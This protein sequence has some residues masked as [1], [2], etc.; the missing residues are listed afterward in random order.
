MDEVL[1]NWS[2][3]FVLTSYDDAAN[4]TMFIAVHSTRLGPAAGGTRI[5]TYPTAGDAL[6]D[7]ARLAAAMTL[8]MAVAGLPMG[9]GKSVLAVE[10]EPLSPEAR[11]GLLRHHAENIER[12]GGRYYTGPDMNTTA[13]DMDMIGE[14]TGRVFGRTP[15]HGGSGSSAPD[16]AVGVFHGI[17]ASVSHVFGTDDVAGRTVMVQGTGAV[18]QPLTEMLVDAGAKVLISDVDSDRADEM[19]ARL[20]VLVVEPDAVVGTECD[21]YAP[22]AVG[23]VLS[24][25][26]IPALRCRIVAGAAN[27]P[28]SAPSDAQLLRAADILYAPDFVI[29]GGGAIHLIGYEALGWSSEQVQRGIRGIGDTLRSIYAAARADGVTTE[30]AAE[31]LAAA[32]LQA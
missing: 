20:P 27:N 24:P 9:G 25:E 16:T 2:G 15:A 31:R 30:E 13:A 26:T 32:R 12:L 28:L 8:K 6:A 3:E 19:S 22:C 11:H 23:G 17:Q 21:V 10:P 4:A 29:N 7:A 18:G 1:R 5:K 14:G